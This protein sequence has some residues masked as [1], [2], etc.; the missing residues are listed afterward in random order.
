M[1]KNA[2]LPNNARE[3]GEAIS[4]A[5]SWLRTGTLNNMK[6]KSSQKYFVKPRSH[7]LMYS[8]CAN[9]SYMQNLLRVHMFLSF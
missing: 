5:K 2:L 3:I 6:I 7:A 8:R 4:F 9:F 1:P